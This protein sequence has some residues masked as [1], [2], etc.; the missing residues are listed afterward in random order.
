MGQTNLSDEHI[1]PQLE[2]R[3]LASLSRDPSLYR[4]LE[5]RKDL[6]AEYSQAFEDLSGAIKADEDVPDVPDDW[7]P[8]GNPESLLNELQ[9]LWERREGA[10]AMEVLRDGV[11]GDRPITDAYDTAVNRLESARGA[12]HAE[13]AGTLRYPG[14]LVP[15]VLEDTQ[16]A[17]EDFQAGGDGITG[18]RS[19][20]GGLDEIL[21]GLQPGLNIISGGPGTGKTSFA[22]QVAADVASGGTPA[23]YITFENTP[24]QLTR[25]GIAA[26]GGHDSRDIRSGRVPMDE[27]RSAAKKWRKRARRLAIVE[28][29]GELT[30][31]Q[32]R[33][34]AQRH[35]NEF[36]AERCLVVVDYLQ[37]YAKVA[38][39]LGGMETRAK[40]EKMGDELRNEVGKRLRSPVL[41]IS[42]QSR[43]GY[44]GEGEAKVRL[45]TLKESGD[46]EYTADTVSF[47]TPPLKDEARQATGEARAM[48]LTVAKNRHGEKGAVELIFRPDRAQ[49]RPEAPREEAE[50][51]ANT[52]ENGVPF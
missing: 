23:L 9:A 33:A 40:V 12:R 36:G 20:I 16:E 2:R 13:E 50:E 52:S 48:D 3:F 30:R 42:S 1:D 45:D 41:A 7:A 25:R 44:N 28:G 49:F 47:L 32:I 17:R 11:Y 35:M 24:K 37:F 6:F 15:D 27:V 43:K 29:H 34:K 10:E 22:H 19:G 51:Q 26:A 4:E 14:D 21:G 39:D 38:A 31:G 46:L 18:V 5:P 8:G